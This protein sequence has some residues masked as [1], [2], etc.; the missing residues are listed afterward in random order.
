MFYFHQALHYY[1]FFKVASKN[2]FYCHEKMFLYPF[3]LRQYV[4][5]YKTRLLRLGNTGR[6][7][8]KNA[9]HICNRLTAKKD[10]RTPYT[11]PL[12]KFWTR[13]TVFWKKKKSFWFR[14][15]KSTSTI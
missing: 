1:W 8:M 11:P 12:A 14:G 2:E 10:D 3:F 4:H 6:K 9:F 7:A 13:S 15:K 5:L